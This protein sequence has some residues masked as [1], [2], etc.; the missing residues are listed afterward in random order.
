MTGNEIPSN[1]E[2]TAISRF[3]EWV[4]DIP[5]LKEL[6]F[7][8]FIVGPVQFVVIFGDTSKTGIGVVAYAV[9]KA[10]E[11]VVHSGIIYS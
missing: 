2:Q 7:H 8:W 5:R 9:T 3:K 10:A 11:G 6:Q 1:I 4:N